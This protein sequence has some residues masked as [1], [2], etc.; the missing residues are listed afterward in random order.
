M[1]S[2]DAVHSL[3]ELPQERPSFAVGR[4]GLESQQALLRSSAEWAIMG[5]KELS[6]ATWGQ[7]VLLDWYGSLGSC[8]HGTSHEE[9]G[10]DQGTR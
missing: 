8:W 6:G 3:E 10:L 9:L 7:A 5:E 1:A 2:V 4:G